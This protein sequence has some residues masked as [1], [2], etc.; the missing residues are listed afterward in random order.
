MEFS[1][2]TQDR[3]PDLTE[4]FIHAFNTPP[5]S[6]NWT[7]ESVSKRLHQ[8]TSSPYDYGL[9]CE[10]DGN[11]AGLIIG[12]EEQYCDEI[13]FTIKEFCTGIDFRGRGLGRKM[14][15]ELEKRLKERGI[16]KIFLTTIQGEGT[17]GVY[18]KL[19]YG[20]SGDMVMMEKEI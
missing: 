5:W 16:D 17:V 19:G 15:S 13:H 3:I 7:H 12:N 6:D 10:I 4:M 9:I 18:R 2:F 8:Q 20:I 11:V 14:M 1:E